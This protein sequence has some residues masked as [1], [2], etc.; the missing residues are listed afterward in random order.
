MPNPTYS[1]VHPETKQPK[2]ARNFNAACK[3]AQQLAREYYVDFVSVV[4]R[5]PDDVFHH[6]C[7]FV[8]PDGT[9]DNK[10]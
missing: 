5:M 8:H 3:R 10:D 7:A 2:P 9:V 6:T 4:S 1:V